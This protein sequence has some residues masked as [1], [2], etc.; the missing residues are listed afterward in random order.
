MSTS[1]VYRSKS[2]EQFLQQPNIEESPA[3]ELVNEVVT[4][5][6]MPTFYHSRLQKKLIKIIDSVSSSYEAFP[7]LRCILTHNSVV[8]DVSVIHRD[9]FPQSNQAIE[10]PPDWGIEI[11][12]PNQ[13]ALKVIAKLELCLQEGMK[14]GWLID[15]ADQVI[16]I[17]W[18]DRPAK[19]I[20]NSMLLP[21]PSDLNLTLTPSE[22]FSWVTEI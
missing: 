7:E 19:I 16:L 18:P 9:R 1:I 8:P 22:V 2:L 14:L 20:Q 15:P 10:G 5:K 17:M 13:S 6:V 4:Q 11:L 12:S 21:L 3:W